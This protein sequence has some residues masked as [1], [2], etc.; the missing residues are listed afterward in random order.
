MII[1]HL[2]SGIGFILIFSIISYTAV[3]QPALPDIAGS[4]ENGSVLLSWVSPY[5]AVKSISVLRS[6]DSDANY[7]I[8][9]YVKNTEK[10][11]EE[12]LDDHPMSGKN[13]YKVTLHFN[14]GLNWTSNR[15]SVATLPSLSPVAVENAAISAKA[16]KGSGR[17]ILSPSSAPMP[18]SDT[19]ATIADSSQAA[20]QKLK[21]SISYE[22]PNS[23]SPTFVTSR[24]ISTDEVTGHVNMNLP[25]DVNQHHYSVKFYNLQNH[26]VVDVP[27]INSS[28]TIFDKR[29]FQR[30]GIYKFIL[31]RDVVE[32]ETG[33]INIY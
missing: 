11:P 3:A 17:V 2:A 15:C 13:F 24:F 23:V 22:D 28:K 18:Q 5:K 16:E 12:F 30:K 33:Y 26:M 32:L 31:R 6:S 27:K 9:G 10:G 19:K 8:I 29:N 14:T 21:I 4:V 25:N 7:S 1:K 20:P